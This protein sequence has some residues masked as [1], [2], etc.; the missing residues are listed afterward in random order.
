MN[1]KLKQEL[2]SLVEDDIRVRAEL[3]A[4]A[5]LFEGYDSRMA[6]VHQRNAQRLDAIIQQHGWPGK[7]LV[8]EEG[9]DAAWLILQHA[10]GD[11]CFEIGYQQ[12]S[13]HRVPFSTQM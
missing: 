6:D 10:I 8:G 5:A 11:R 9:A 2:L 7:S 4:S 3:A 12:V 1:N 13:P